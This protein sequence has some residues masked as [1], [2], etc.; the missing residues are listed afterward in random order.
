L[1]SG[2]VYAPVHIALL[3]V[4]LYKSKEKR[5]EKIKN[6]ITGLIKSCL[7]AASM[8]L[9]IP[10]ASCRVWGLFNEGNVKPNLA[11]VLS[12]VWACFFLF[13]SKHR[14]GEM[15]IWV[16]ANWLESYKYSLEKRGMMPDIPFLHVNFLKS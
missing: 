7:F 12:G 16:L 10:M 13:E 1:N 15:S 2:K 14:Y 4:R 6:A 5:L 11:F 8:S 9:A 3:L